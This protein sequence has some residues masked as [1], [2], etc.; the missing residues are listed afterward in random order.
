MQQI[1]LLGRQLGIQKKLLDIYTD[2]TETP[3]GYLRIDLLPGSNDTYMLKTR[4]FPDED[5]VVYK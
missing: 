4:I 5:T 3:F 1:K 2:A